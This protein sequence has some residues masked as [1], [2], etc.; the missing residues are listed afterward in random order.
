MSAEYL[1][2]KYLKDNKINNINVSS[3]WTEADPEPPY[4]YTLNRLE[5]Y[6]CDASE[7][8]QTKIT[9]EFLEDQDL[10]ICMAKHHQDF[11]EKM[12]YKSVLFNFVVYGKDED[13]LDEW[14]YEQ[15]HWPIKDLGKYVDKIVD[16][17]HDAIPV[18]IKRIDI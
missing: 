14:E 12:W 1:T 10:I 16:Y 13:V 9:K 6:W 3:A 2:K 4:L 11:I 17:I 7:H 5:Y 15:I 8:K 18:L